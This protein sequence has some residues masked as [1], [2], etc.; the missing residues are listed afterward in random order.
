VKEG[1]FRLDRRKKFF[2]MRV[3]ETLEQVAHRGGRCPIPGNTQG[4]GPLSNLD[5]AEDVPSH[6]QRVELDGL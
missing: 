6:C 4:Q 5:L 1:R 3:V 2:M